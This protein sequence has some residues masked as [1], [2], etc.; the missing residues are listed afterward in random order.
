[1]LLLTEDVANRQKAQKD[2]IPVMSLREY[3]QGMRDGS[4]LLDLLAAEGPGTVEPPNTTGERK[5]L[6]PEARFFKSGNL[7]CNLNS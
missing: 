1:M 7:Y 4:Q 5:V 6:Y 2:G 3:V